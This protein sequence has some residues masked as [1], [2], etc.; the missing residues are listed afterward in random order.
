MLN[1]RNPHFTA[2]PSQPS[3][4]SPDNRRGHPFSR[5]YGA[6]LPSSLTRVLSSAL[7]F[8]T[9]LP[10]SVCST[11]TRQTHYEAFLGS[12]GLASSV[13]LAAFLLVTSR[14]L[15]GER[16]CLLS[17]PTGLNRDIRHPDG[18]PFSVTP[19]L[20]R[21]SGGTGILTC[22]PSPTPFGLGLGPD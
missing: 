16:I 4:A 2:A 21:V 7:V 18:L 9:R 13:R 5:S 6:R 14:R 17:P 19:S 3:G 15:I 8:S 20:K 11:S 10:E 1:S 12:V 22:F